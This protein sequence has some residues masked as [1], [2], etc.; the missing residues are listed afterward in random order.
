MQAIVLQHTGSAFKPKDC[1]FK[2]QQQVPAP[3]AASAAQKQKPPQFK[4]VGKTAAMDL[5]EY[6]DD[7]GMDVEEVVMLP[8]T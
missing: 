3:A 6:C 7:S 4:T 5:A 1:R 8:L 2:V